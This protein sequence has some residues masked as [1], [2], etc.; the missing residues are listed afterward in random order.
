MTRWVNGEVA[1]DAAAAGNRAYPPS[2]QDYQITARLKTERNLVAAEV[3]SGDAS[4]VPAVGRRRVTRRPRGICQS[5]KRRPCAREGGSPI[6]REPP[7]SERLPPP[8]G[9]VPALLA[10]LEPAC[11]LAGLPAQA[12]ETPVAV[13]RVVATADTVLCPATPRDAAGSAPSL[14]AGQSGGYAEDGHLLI[15]FD[16]LPAVPAR[17]VLQVRLGLYRE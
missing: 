8:W 9:I 2:A 12:A 14:R 13:L 1:R 15:R 10:A 17:D 4:F 11:S 7:A 5:L 3:V 6:R 16:D